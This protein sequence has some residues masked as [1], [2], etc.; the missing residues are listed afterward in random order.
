MGAIELFAVAAEYLLILVVLGFHY[1]DF[2]VLLSKV[3]D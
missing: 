1:V 2:F 3:I